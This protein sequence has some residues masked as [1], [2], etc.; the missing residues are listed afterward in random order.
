[1]KI[2][3]NNHSEKKSWHAVCDFCD[4][5]LEYSKEDVTIKESHFFYLHYIKCPCCGKSVDVKH[6]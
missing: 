4:S 2:I 5:V 6:W 1:M 3:E